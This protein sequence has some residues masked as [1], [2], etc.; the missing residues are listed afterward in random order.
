MTGTVRTSADPRLATHW[1]P[2]LARLVPVPAEHRAATVD[3][4][5]A[6]RELGCPPD[7]PAALV[8]AGLPAEPT[9]DGPRLDLHDVMN[10]G[11]LSG[12][13][14][15]SAEL[16]ER[17]LMGLAAGD[18]DRWVA[19]KTWRISLSAA[20][21]AGCAAPVRPPQPA[22]ETTGGELHEWLPDPADPAE[23]QAVLTTRGRLDAPRTPAVREIHDELYDALAS[24]RR[25]Y[26][27]LPAS[28]DVPTADAF[29]T[30]NCVV[31]AGLMAQR[32]AEAGLTA[33]TRKGVLI[34]L[35]GV[36]HAW[37]EVRED[38]RWVPLD[39]VLA[40]LAGR[41]PGSGGAFADFCR[42]STPNRLLAWDLPADRDFVQ[43]DCAGRAR[44][45]LRLRLMPIASPD[46]DPRGV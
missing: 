44:A 33:R 36:E 14:R 24:G 31:A 40:F 2:A 1:L 8:S 3:L 13:G 21:P 45:A 29:G 46:P 18:P 42:G 16:G 28:M 17:R 12:T 6:A 30:V 9:A 7:V 32:A 22:P 25:R 26:G 37:T 23:V 35:V 39:P 5:D 19:A 4:P 15:S 43:H 38:D 41:T 34:G 10:L 20:C 11:L 27:W